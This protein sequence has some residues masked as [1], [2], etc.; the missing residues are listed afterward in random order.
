MGTYCAVETQVKYP[1]IGGPGVPFRERIKIIAI[2][3]GIYRQIL[4][5]NAGRVPVAQVLQR[6]VDSLPMAYRDTARDPSSNLGLRTFY[7]YFTYRYIFFYLYNLKNPPDLFCIH[8]WQIEIEQV[9]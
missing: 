2:R 6:L 5:S 9:L 8:S 3:N 7:F 1:M 4:L